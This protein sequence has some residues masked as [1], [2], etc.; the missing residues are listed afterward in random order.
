MVNEGSVFYVTNR[1]NS[2][3]QFRFA[4]KYSCFQNFMELK[5]ISEKYG[6]CSHIIQMFQWNK[7]MKT[8]IE[9]SPI[10]EKDERNFRF[11]MGIFT[12][13]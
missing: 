12:Q 6:M 4:E 3:V 7:E 13:Q 11:S 9:T 10:S 1:T 5:S 8:Y 2:E